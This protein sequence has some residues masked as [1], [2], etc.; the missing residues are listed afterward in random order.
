VQ[1]TVKRWR[2]EQALRYIAESAVRIGGVA[3]RPAVQGHRGYRRG[4]IN[5][6]AGLRGTTRSTGDTAISVTS[7]G[8]ATGVPHV[9]IA[10]TVDEVVAREPR[11]PPV[12][13][14][15]M[16]RPN[17]AAPSLQLHYRAFDTVGSEEARS[18][19]LA[20]ASVRRSN[21]A[22]SFPAPSFHK[23]AAR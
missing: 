7:A 4:T 18:I 19:A 17:D 14:W 6:P 20:L 23:D 3:V 11:V 1:R 21:W 10:V 9:E 2:A 8:E 22:C 5:N 15:P 16:A 13:G 12:S